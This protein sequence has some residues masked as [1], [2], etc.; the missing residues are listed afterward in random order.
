MCSMNMYYDRIKKDCELCPK[1]EAGKEYTENCGYNETGYPKTPGV[2]R[3]KSCTP[4]DSFKAK[5]STQRCQNCQECERGK[6]QTAPC[7]VT[8]DTVCANECPKG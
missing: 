2:Q 3:C 6:V 5:E 1:C 8:R 4:G 7:T